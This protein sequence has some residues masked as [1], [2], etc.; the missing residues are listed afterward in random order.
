MHHIWIRLNVSW[1]CDWTYTL[2]CM[3]PMYGQLG[4][5]FRFIVDGLIHNGYVYAGLNDDVATICV[6]IVGE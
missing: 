5:Y 6:L 3:V 2:C 1:N 4:V